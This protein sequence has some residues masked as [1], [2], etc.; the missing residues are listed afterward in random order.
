MNSPASASPA[1]LEQLAPAHAPAPPGWWP[2]APGWWLL[3][4]MLA[5]C[6]G[7]FYAWRRERRSL[8]RLALNE[9]AQIESS[10][11][12]DAALA[13]D[14]ENLMRRYAVSRY[15]R[16]QVARLSGDDWIAFVAAH[17]GSALAGDSG[18]Q[19][20]RA[21][22]GAAASADRAQWLLGARGFIGSRH[23]GSKRK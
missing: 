1:W 9:L 17:G 8:R 14:L 3:L 2:P 13:R 11:A 5:L 7:L 16:E 23:F 20:L 21:A 15:G 4:A 12:D 19:L 22:Y 6:A 10:A 18:R